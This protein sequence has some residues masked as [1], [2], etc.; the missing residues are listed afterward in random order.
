MLVS[1]LVIALAAAVIGGATMAW[2]TD[3]DESAPVTFTAGTLLVDIEKFD[4]VN[5]NEINLD[6]LNPGD[7][8]GYEVDVKN[9]GTK[10][11]IY[12]VLI[13]WQDILGN[14]LVD[15][16][17]REGFGTKP[18]SD[19]IVFTVKKGNEIITTGTLEGKNSPLEFEIGQLAPGATDSY[20]IEAVL[21][22]TAGNE[23]QGSK[24]KLAFVV[25]AK[26]IQNGA[27]YGE[28]ECPLLDLFPSTN[29]LNKQKN[30]PRRPGQDA[31]YVELVSATE[32]SVTL[33]FVNPTGPA[34]VFEVRIDGKDPTSTPH[35]AASYSFLD[36]DEKV[37]APYYT[38][39]N[40]NTEQT[41]EVS[42][43]VEV[44]HA[45]GAESDWYFDWTTFYPVK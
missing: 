36:D 22:T 34:A 18:L 24:M 43:K 42:D 21:P 32:E 17:G 7:D 44:R 9:S 23:Y 33:N 25:M 1:L 41:F 2:F 3:A 35:W 40:G 11:F 12:K 31:P 4:L 19:A 14:T 38:V 29:L 26:Q 45:A 16:G 30:A 15:F 20:T 8:W 10:N 13:C 27:E 28:F 6:I 39:T 5:T 37:Y